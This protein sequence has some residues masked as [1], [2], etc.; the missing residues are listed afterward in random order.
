MR[1]RP[2]FFPSSSSLY[3]CPVRKRT[4]EAVGLLFCLLGFLS[5]SLWCPGSVASSSPF[6][7]GNVWGLTW[8][9][10]PH[11]PPTTPLPFCA[12]QSHCQGLL[13]PRRGCHTP[14]AP[15][16]EEKLRSFEW[17]LYV[18]S[19]KPWPY[20][21]ADGQS[22]AF[23]PFLPP[24][25]SPKACFLGLFPETLVWTCKSTFCSLLVTQGHLPSPPLG[26]WRC[27]PTLPNGRS[28]PTSDTRFWNSFFGI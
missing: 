17:Y 7:E 21:V 24:A 26:P 8:V 10:P 22:S 27:V 3:P 11:W 20:K 13:S 18:H 23:S 19:A 2:L 15:T 12:P 25:I 28:P 6:L 1:P 14:R 4:E 9:G 16:E 5:W